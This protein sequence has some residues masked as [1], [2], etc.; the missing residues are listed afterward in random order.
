MKEI[1]RPLPK[2][3]SRIL[4]PEAQNLATP[5]LP[6]QTA[7]SA[8]LL[9]LALLA[10]LVWSY[11]DAF[12]MLGTRWINEPDFSHGFF[13][14]AFAIYLLYH[15]RE[16]LPATPSATWSSLLTGL[17]LI[18][19]TAVTR[20]TGIYQQFELLDPLS[21][22][23]CLFAVA[24]VYGGWPYARWAW[25]AIAFLIFM[26]PLPGFISGQLSGPLQ[27]IGTIASTFVLQTIG[28]PAIAQGN[29]ICL[30]EGRI[31]V[32]EACSGLRML[33]VFFSITV[34]AAFILKRPLWEKCFIVMSAV[35]IGIIT[36]VF[37]ITITGIAHEYFGRELADHLFHDL[38][39][40]LMMP[41]A[42]ALL[43]LECG[44]LS[45]LLVAPN[46]DRVGLELSTSSG[47]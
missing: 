15:R 8:W 47:R 34:G 9:L 37:R 4:Q 16:M 18:A 44:L 24:L 11:A 17:A 20:W 31:G 30:T 23:P 33:T 2:K 45:K 36:N 19:F 35:I 14:P 28:I 42:I 46:S 13:V 22:I 25:P 1:L 39:G 21:I 27:R 38:A 41:I 26:I 12:W 6:E 32:V 29:V 10:A 40:L 3:S 5:F 43:L 7:T